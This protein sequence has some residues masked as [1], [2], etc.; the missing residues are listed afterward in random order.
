MFKPWRDLPV[1]G[2][3][4]EDERDVVR[5]FLLADPGTEGLHHLREMA[6]SGRWRWRCT[7]SISRSSPNSPNSFSGSVTPSL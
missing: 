6:A 1:V 5:L 2:L 7:I 4:G 3:A